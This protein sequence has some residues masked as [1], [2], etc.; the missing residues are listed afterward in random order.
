MARDGYQCQEAKRYGK[1]VP[2]TVVHHIFP[3]AE[4]PQY[5]FAAWNLIALSTD[6]HNQMHDRNTNE[7][8]DK[9]REWMERTARK[10][11]IEL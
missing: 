1:A 6:A 4:F 2:A 11:G 3:V 7:L 10:Y 8:T 9:G 5:R